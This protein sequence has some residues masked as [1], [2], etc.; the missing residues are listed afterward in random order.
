MLQEL[1]RFY[2]GIVL[3]FDLQLVLKRG[4]VPWCE[5]GEEDLD[6]PRLGWCAWLKTEDFV[7]DA[8]HALFEF[9]G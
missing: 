7:N 1:T 5:L 2:L 9:R 3:S 6:G 4:D 8:S